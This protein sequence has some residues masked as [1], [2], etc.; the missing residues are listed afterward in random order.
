MPQQPPLACQSHNH[1]SCI[2]AAILAAGR[3]CRERSVRLTPL[4]QQVLTLIWQSHK[5][6]G[7]YAIMDMLAAATTRRIAPPT[8]YRAL[9]FLLEHRLIHRINSLN[10]YIGCPEPENQHHSYFLICSD[11]GIA[12]ECTAKYLA[13]AIAK[14]AASTGFDID[15]QSVEIIGRCPSCRKR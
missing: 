6:L 7:A 15:D 11:C 3:I 5:P 1:Q 4:R 8:V 2:D 10:A 12:T 14:T 13:P 9:E